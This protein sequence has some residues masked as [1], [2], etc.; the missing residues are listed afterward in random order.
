MSGQIPAEQPGAAPESARALRYVRHDDGVTARGMTVSMKAVAAADASIPDH[1]LVERMAR[2]D[3]RAAQSLVDRHGAALY[4]LARS[5][6]QDAAD[7]EEVA[8]DA[9]LQAWR[10]ADTFDPTR[11][12]V[13]AWLAMITRSRALDRMRSRKS[14][15]RASEREL[16]REETRVRDEEHPDRETEASEAR[17]L[18]GKALEDLPESQR[19]VIELAYFSGL[20]QSEIAERLAV[21]LGTVKTRTLSA[22]K[23]LRELLAPLLREEVA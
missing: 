23:R 19:R 5:I 17:T 7:A 8:A 3:E 4:A 13:I 20:S 1:V 6:L 2:G 15:P 21:P 18:V 14:A 9:F 22:M 10:R 11:A 16:E 12:S